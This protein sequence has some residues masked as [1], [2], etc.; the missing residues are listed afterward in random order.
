MR[1]R[2]IPTDTLPFLKILPAVIGG[3][4]IADSFVFPIW[5]LC[6]TLFAA[7]GAAWHW[8]DLPQSTF[9][10]LSALLLGAM[11]S[12]HLFRS[13]RS[14]PEGERI[15]AVLQIEDT[16]VIT[17][18]WQRVSATIIRFR[19]END[20][21]STWEDATEKTIL[22]IDTCFGPIS[23]GDRIVTTARTSGIA[24]TAF[25]SYATLMHRRGYGCA[26]WIGP[27]ENPIV[28]PGK[29]RTPRYYAELLRNKAISRIDRLQIDQES[30]AICKAMSLGMR[31]DLP[32]SL[33]TS[34][35]NTGT[36]HLLAVSGL[37][38]GIVA[39]LINLLLYL[40]PIADKGHIL[41]NIIAI[42]A[43][44]FYAFLTGLSP[45]SIRAAIM[46]SCIQIALAAS[47]SGNGMNFLLGAAT[48]M[49][50]IYPDWFY[51]LSFQL[52]FVAVFGI[53]ILFR[54][55]FRVVESRFRLLNVMWSI[56]IVGITAT[57]TTAPLSAYHFGRIGIATLFLNP[58]V[59]L[60]ANIIV[61]GSIIWMLMPLD[62]L[63]PLFSSLLEGAAGI[64]NRIIRFCDGRWWTSIEWSPSLIQT[65]LVYL[66]IAIALLGIRFYIAT[67]RKPLLN[68]T[69]S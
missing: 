48:V 59:I 62:V 12:V 30:R 18:Q 5:V 38:V 68:R 16:P 15:T 32:S 17:G 60:T 58:V 55:L 34:Y 63:N 4:L 36:S 45:S 23:A 57:L 29:T 39:L 56:I 21:T 66:A 52:S 37:H 14:I 61:F 43:I 54:P 46:F 69:E 24:G 65:L 20:L 11:L 64:Q 10:A 67:H 3:I 7:L 40:L 41:K 26:L 6:I 28:L 8:R 47:L 9:Y 25:E 53:M 51:D 35:G 42:G 33:K 44:W 1:H 27:Q 19:L 13:E 49:L 31:N 50:L 2:I 22:R